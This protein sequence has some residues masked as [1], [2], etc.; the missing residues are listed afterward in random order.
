MSQPNYKQLTSDKTT[1]GLKYLDDKTLNQ[2][3]IRDKTKYQT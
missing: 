1:Q 2:G 3:L